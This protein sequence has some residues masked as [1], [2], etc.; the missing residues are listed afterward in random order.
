MAQRILIIEDE[1]PL[2]EEILDI[3]SYEGFDVVGAS[4]GR[5]GIERVKEQKPDLIVSDIMMPEMDGYE[6][7][8]NIR[9]NPK[10]FDIPFIF[11]TAKAAK[12]DQRRGMDI[13]A[14]DYLT[15]PFSNDLLISAIKTRLARRKALA[16]QYESRV[17]NLHGTVTHMLPHELRTPLTGILGYSE[18][19]AEDGLTMQGKTVVTMANAIYSSGMRLYR[20]VENFLLFAQ[21]EVFLLDPSRL[22]IMSGMTLKQPHELLKETAERM[23]SQK[24]RGSDFSMQIEPVSEV[25]C[26]DRSLKKIVEEI[27][28]NAIKFSQKDTPI[29]LSAWC[30]GDDYIIS[31][32]NEGRGMTAE[33]IEAIGPYQQFERERYE[34]QGA[35]LGLVIS[36]RLTEFHGG[37]FK[38]ESVPG[39]NL[40]VHIACRI[41]EA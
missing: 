7:L 26:D 34:Q 22:S 28:D 35:G 8:V 1:R 37:K 3:L 24:Q 9:E 5:E 10:T 2:L 6:V 29:A 16:E 19:M 13:G 40:T 38:V 18:I 32:S 31:V 14:D 33:Q 30:D 21:T 27:L 41:N 17:N 4:N 12:L 23:I 39:E 20:T 11:L 25:Y 15:K 36:Q